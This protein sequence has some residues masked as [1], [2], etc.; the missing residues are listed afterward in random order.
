[1][2]QGVIGI[3]CGST[4]CKGVLRVGSQIKAMCLLPTGWSPKQSAVGVMER[5]LGEAA[6]SR[7]DVAVVSTGYGRVGID[8]ADHSITEI[9]CHAMGAHELHGGVGAIVDI[10]GQDCKAIAVQDGKVTAFQMNDKCAA[11]TGRFLEMTAL[12]LGAELDEFQRLLDAGQ[13]CTIGSMCAVFADSEIV[14]LLAAG[15]SREAIAGGVIC[16][17]AARAAALAARV[18]FRDTVFLTGGLS[19]IKGL[20]DALCEKLQCRVETSKF[21]QF[22]GAIGAASLGAKRFAI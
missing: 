14:S 21:A 20:R 12:R 10:G 11:G 18:E 7:Q 3:D 2:M 19:Q 5:L 8:F 22:A 16:A 15:E 1:M 13:R 17:I 6:L 9:S 4:A